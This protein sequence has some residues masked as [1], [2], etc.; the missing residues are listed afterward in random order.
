MSVK[1]L[2]ILYSI[3]IERTND[4]TLSIERT[5]EYRKNMVATATWVTEYPED[6]GGEG[7][8]DA[9]LE[10][11]R[12]FSVYLS[13]LYDDVVL[14]APCTYNGRICIYFEVDKKCQLPGVVSG[15]PVVAKLRAPEACDV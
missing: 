8:R 3:S 6:S 4:Y 13:M 2:I 11:I 12:D 10:Y 1:K 5:K 7:D 9:L 14:I 15:F